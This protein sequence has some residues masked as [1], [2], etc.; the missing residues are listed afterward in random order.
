M[1]EININDLLSYFKSKVVYILM[2]VA[3]VTGLGLAYKL[4][5]EKPVYESSTSLILTGFT[6]N[7]ESDSSINNN[8]LTINQKLLPTYQEI[9][10]S[11]KVLLEVIDDLHLS[12]EVEELAGNISVTG[13][14][15]TEIIK[16]TVTDKDA[17]TAYQIVSKIADVFSDEVRD[18]YNVSNV[19]ILDVPEVADA[20]SNMNALKFV[21][22][23]ICAGFV[24]ACVAIFVIYYFDTTIKSVDQI[25]SKLDVPVLGS[26]P[27]YNQKNRGKK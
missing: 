13:V 12:Y 26:I 8:D 20:P 24:L 6:N 11:R 23:C 1:E 16:I 22:L 21:F 10:K 3:I 7:S 2:I 4:I 9:T 27:D 25:E 19:S 17:L 18:I 15:D 14:T 5:F